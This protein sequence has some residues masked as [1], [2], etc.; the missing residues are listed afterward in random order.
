MGSFLDNPSQDGV[1]QVEAL[2]D[3]CA[4]V[5][6][7]RARHLDHQAWLAAWESLLKQALAE[8]RLGIQEGEDEARQGFFALAER[9]AQAATTT[10]AR[11]RRGA[12]PLSLQ[13]TVG[14]LFGHHLRAWHAIRALRQV[15]GWTGD[16]GT[17]VGGRPPILLLDDAALAQL[18]ELTVDLLW[19]LPLSPGEAAHLLNSLAWG[20]RWRA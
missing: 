8:G 4:E 12:I 2:A 16:R 1:Y 15:I 9:L 17:P 18:N 5:P 3:L 20:W 14:D 13:L 7:L 6:E 19:A 11:A 10:L